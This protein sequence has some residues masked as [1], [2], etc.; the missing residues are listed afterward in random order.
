MDLARHP[1]CLGKW[2]VF[3]CAS[4]SF[5]RRR[6]GGPSL[7]RGHAGKDIWGFLH[8]KGTD[9]VRVTKANALLER[10]HEIM[11]ELM[12]IGVPFYLEN[13]VDSKLRCHPCVRKWVKH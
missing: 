8:L 9:K 1:D 2:F 7:L 10:L 11:Q 12:P 5:A 4:F 6:H 13:P 3:R